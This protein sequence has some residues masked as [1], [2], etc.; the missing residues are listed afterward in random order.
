MKTIIYT[1]TTKKQ[2]KKCA[3]IGVDI[4]GLYPLDEAFKPWQISV[5]KARQIILS[6]RDKIH[7]TVITHLADIDEIVKIAKATNP[8]NVQLITPLEEIGM[9]NLKRLRTKLNEI[10]INLIFA[11]GVVGE[12]SVETAKK[13]SKVVDMI[14]L[15]TRRQ[16]T[17]QDEKISKKKWAIGATGKVNDWNIGE[18]IV[19]EVNIPVILA[20]GLGPDN[21]KKAIQKV[22]P[23]GVDSM[24]KTDVEGTNHLEKDFEKIENFVSEAK[25]A[26]N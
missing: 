6:L 16:K 13:L 14:I 7:F 17:D 10:D 24:T 8:H 9:D 23:W 12:E 26:S 2:A 3:E 18:K 11:V 21:V 15:D 20:G 19:N 25:S 5:R 22:Q 4:I 1:I